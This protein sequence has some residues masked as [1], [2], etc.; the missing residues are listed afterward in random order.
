MYKAIRRAGKDDP[1]AIKIT[2]RAPS[3][4]NAPSA[5]A[6]A[7]AAAAAVAVSQGKPANAGALVASVATAALN[8][9]SKD[10]AAAGGAGAAAGGGASA[11]NPAAAAA[12]AA[13]A[14]AA[15][16]ETRAREDTGPDEGIPL[17]A[18]REMA[19]L[20][21]LKHP[22]ITSLLDTKLDR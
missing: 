22:N 17:Q 10:G 7:A 19:L 9:L 16:A 20:K 4:A 8:N 2:K 5:A 15:V 13:A 11:G 1:V 6:A 3:R 18:I 12:A 21:E 14:S